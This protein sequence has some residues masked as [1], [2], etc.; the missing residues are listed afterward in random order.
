MLVIRGKDGK[1]LTDWYRKP[2]YSGRCVNFFSSHP[3]QFKFNAIANLVDQA[4]LLS[5]RRFH[6]TN[7]EI[8]KYILINNCYP[9]SVINRKIK[10]RLATIRKNRITASEKTK[11]DNTDISKILVI[12]YIKEIS[13]GIKRVVGKGVDVRYTIPKKL[14]CIIKKGKDRLDTRLNTDVVYK[15]DCIDCE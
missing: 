14:D 13:N 15:I 12:P 5:D 8:V 9:L 1:I 4:I 7:I 3:E 6:E 11:D 2:T 10:E